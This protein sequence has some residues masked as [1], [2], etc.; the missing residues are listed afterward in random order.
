MREI[1]IVC[2]SHYVPLHSSQAGLRFGRT[3]FELQVTENYASRLVRLPM[4][5]ME[6]M[7][8]ERI[9]DG[10]FQVSEKIEALQ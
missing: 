1:E 2:A 5:S 6:R 9:V 8:V 10:I 7:P 3:D 4:W